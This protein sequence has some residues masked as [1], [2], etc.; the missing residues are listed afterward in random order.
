M[1]SLFRAFIPGTQRI[2]LNPEKIGTL[3]IITPERTL[4]LNSGEVCL[5]F[6]ATKSI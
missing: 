3:T 4:T 6:Y 1:A 5:L 2:I